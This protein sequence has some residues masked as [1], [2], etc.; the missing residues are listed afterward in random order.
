MAQMTGR[1]PYAVVTIKKK[2]SK[3]KVWPVEMCRKATM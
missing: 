2:S 1:R 3:N